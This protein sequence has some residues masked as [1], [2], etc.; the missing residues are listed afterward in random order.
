MLIDR[1]LWFWHVTGQN[2]ERECQPEASF[3][4]GYHERY[5]YFRDDFKSAYPNADPRTIKRLARMAA[6][7]PK[8]P[9]SDQVYRFWAICCFSASRDCP[10]M[11]Q[12][13][14]ADGAGIMVEYPAPEGSSA[15]L[16]GKVKYTDEPVQIDLCHLDESD[17]YRVFTTKTLKW[18]TER[19]YRLVMRLEEPFSGKSIV[20]SD[21]QIASVTVGP[22]L[23]GAFL[24][25]VRSTCSE[26]GIEIKNA[27]Q[28]HAAERPQAGGA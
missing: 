7:S 14:G 19:E 9:R 28:A 25:R 24:D 4:G 23:E 10:Y 5:R 8:V 1:S 11:W 21:L 2:D 22:R 15:G 12:Q 3:D 16:A 17:V 26:H 13:Y 20:F 6:N 18:S 27:Q